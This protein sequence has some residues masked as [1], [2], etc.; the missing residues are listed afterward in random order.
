MDIYLA[1]MPSMMVSLAASATDVQLTLS[2]YMFG[3]GLAQ[4]VAGPISDRIGRRPA[5]IGGL[6]LFIAA[7]LVCALA[8]T[9]EAL[10]AARFVQAL[11]LAPIAVVPRA[12]VRDLISGDRAAQ[13]LSLMG[14]VLGIAPVA[15]P[16]LGSHLHQWFGWQSTFVFVAAYGTVLLVLVMRMLPETIATRDPKATDPATMLANFRLLL[17]SRR[18]WRYLLAAS[19]SM[20]G[21]FAFLAGSAFVFISVLGHSETGF[22]W[23]FG[24]VMLGN[25]T[26][27]G[28]GSALVRRWGIDR[29]ILRASWLM[30][31]AGLALGLLAWLDTAHPL[32]VVV[33]MFAYMTA[34]SIILPQSIAGALTPFPAIAGSASSLLAFVQFV[35]AALAASVVGLAHD[36]TGRPMATVIAVAGVLTFAGFRVMRDRREDA[37]GR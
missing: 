12:V 8:T 34:L 24:V 19:F 15:A 35:S 23:M 1:S 17:A 10:I 25:I 33:P 20:C 14:M 22:G 37:A 36:G 31:G 5:L 13:M 6:L 28:I 27:A 4:L 3:W 9:V 26:G 21:V 30:L 18:Y 29:L 16:I 7:S 32:A 11:A 2:V